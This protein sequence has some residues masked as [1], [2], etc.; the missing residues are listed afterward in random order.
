MTIQRIRPAGVEERLAAPARSTSCRRDAE[1]DDRAR[2]PNSEMAWASS[3]RRPGSAASSDGVEPDE[4]KGSPES[5]TSARSMKAA[6]AFGDQA[7]VVAV[8]QEEARRSRRASR[9]SGRRRRLDLDHPRRPA[10]VSARGDGRRR[11]AAAICVGRPIRQR[12]SRRRAGRGYW[13]SICVGR[14]RRMALPRTVP[15]PEH[16]VGSR[17]SVTPVCQ[18]RPSTE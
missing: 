18:P 3:A 14:G 13:R 5:P 15:R 16:L 4:A 6:R 8:D 10:A 1:R 9:G 12:G 17:P 7:G 2:P 11:R